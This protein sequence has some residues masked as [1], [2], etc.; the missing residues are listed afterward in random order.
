MIEQECCVSIKC[1]GA[2]KIFTQNAGPG[3]AEP[4]I[5]FC[6]SPSQTD[7]GKIGGGWISFVF[8]QVFF[9]MTKGLIE[10]Y[11][12]ALCLGATPTLQ[13]GLICCSLD[14]PTKLDGTCDTDE[15]MCVLFRHLF[16]S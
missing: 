7:C 9:D 13:N 4:D 8:L 10:H 11:R 6:L 15:R 16:N 5:S 2:A 12:D 3:L 14:R 1:G